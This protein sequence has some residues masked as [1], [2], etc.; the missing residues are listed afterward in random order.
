[1]GGTEEVRKQ[2]SEQMREDLPFGTEFVVQQ[3]IQVKR[4]LRG[5]EGSAG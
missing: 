1:M 2:E 3:T 5:A 4:R